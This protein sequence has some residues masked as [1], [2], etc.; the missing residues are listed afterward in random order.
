LE[1]SELRIARTLS[2]TS[3]DQRQ[4]LNFATLGLGCDHILLMYAS[5]PK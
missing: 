2:L 4:K 1:I 3:G 5:R